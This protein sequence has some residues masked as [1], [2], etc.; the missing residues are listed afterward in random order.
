MQVFPGITLLVLGLAFLA[1]PLV[2]AG[3]VWDLG[4]AVGFVAVAGL[5]YLTIPTTGVRNLA[6]HEWFSKGV[7][8]LCVFHAIWL[9]VFDPVVITYLT[10]GRA[11]PYMWIGVLSLFAV[12]LSIVI[13]EQTVRSLWFS[14]HGRFKTVH[15]ATGLVALAGATY[16]VLASGH[17]LVTWYQQLLFVAV[18]LLVCVYPTLRQFLRQYPVTNLWVLAVVSMA[19]SVAFAMIRNVEL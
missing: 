5:M 10:P 15:K 16:H 11:P 19:A 6:A 2:G 12:A 7:L 13:S 8:V 4:N 9:L 14:D 3:W 1:N 18:A 17:Y